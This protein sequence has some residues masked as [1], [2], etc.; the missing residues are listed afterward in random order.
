MKN[1]SLIYDFLWITISAILTA[2]AVNLIFSFTGLAPGGITGLCIIFSTITGISVDIMT[3][4]MSLP[5]LVLGVI[6]IGKSFGIKTLYITFLT[7]LCMR[8]IPSIPITEGL[9]NIHPILELAIAALV[10]GL[11]VG[12]A[13]GIALNRECAT[14][15]T[16]LIALLIQH[17]IKV[18]KV[19]HILFVLDGSVVIASGIINQ[20]ALIAVFSFLS[21]MVIIQTINFFTTKKIAAPRNQH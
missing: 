11:L 21:L 15:G 6:F 19:P 16:D 9:K 3:L 1:K 14:G 5:L 20:N 17:F 8:L 12:A 10:G 13:I 7:P 18:L 2:M 4:C